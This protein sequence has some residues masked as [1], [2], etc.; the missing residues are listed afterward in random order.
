MEA[1]RIDLLRRGS[2]RDTRR[3]HERPYDGRRDVRR[4]TLPV[5]PRSAL[6]RRIDAILKRR[7][8]CA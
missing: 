5:D 4:G 3:N 2:V 7:R 1:Y 8:G 6:E